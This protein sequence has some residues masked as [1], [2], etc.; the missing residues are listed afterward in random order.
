MSSR[1]ATFYI[2]E[3][4]RSFITEFQAKNSLKSP[5]EALRKILEY[6]EKRPVNDDAELDVLSRIL[7]ENTERA[8]YAL[9]E[10][11]SEI[12]STK[13]FLRGHDERH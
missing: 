13:R 5:S 9:S 1:K 7:K 6:A 4:H 11:F 12:E 3:Q 2:D 10:A 8:R